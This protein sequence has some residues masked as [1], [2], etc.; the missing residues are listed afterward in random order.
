MN[1]SIS[2]SYY[3]QKM[4]VPTKT[5]TKEERKEMEERITKDG[6]GLKTRHLNN[7]EFKEDEELVPSKEKDTY[8]TIN[9]R[10]TSLAIGAASLALLAVIYKKYSQE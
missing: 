2:E 6:F 9:K 5:L 10:K 8:F 7:K 1:Q 4:P 3:P